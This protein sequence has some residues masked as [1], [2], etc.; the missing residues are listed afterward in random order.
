MLRNSY[1]QSWRDEPSP[2]AIWCCG[3]PGVCKTVLS[4]IIA[5]HLFTITKCKSKPIVICLFCNYQKEN[6]QTASNF[7]ANMAK[8]MIQQLSSTSLLED[9]KKFY[10]NKPHSV[11]AFGELVEP[12]RKLLRL[13]DTTFIIIDALHETPEQGSIRKELIPFLQT[14]PIRLLVTSR[15]EETIKQTFADSTC[16]QI[17]AQE[18]DIMRYV[19]GRILQEKL[20]MRHI[21]QRPSLEQEIVGKIVSGAKGM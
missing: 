8:Q 14:V 7:L 5:Q 4:S 10:D 15:Y 6:E 12:F 3:G 11:P 13:C 17:L 2:R 19:Q 16:M 9:V 1:F 21:R 18:E 20:L